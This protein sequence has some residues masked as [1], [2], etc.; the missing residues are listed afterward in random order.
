M[1]LSA[2]ELGYAEDA[3]VIEVFSIVL[4]CIVL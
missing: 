3:G 1:A 2:F 4:Y